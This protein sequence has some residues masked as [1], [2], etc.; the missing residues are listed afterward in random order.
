[1]ID[2]IDELNNALNVLEKRNNQNSWF[3]RLVVRADFIKPVLRHNSFLSIT[4]IRRAK[5]ERCQLTKN[6]YAHL[7]RSKA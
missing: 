5:Y 4:I 3:V 1:M 2:M 7:S 6:R